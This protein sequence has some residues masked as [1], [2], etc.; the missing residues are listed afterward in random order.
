MDS[1]VRPLW[2]GLW[3][4]KDALLSLPTPGSGP[5]TGS[6]LDLDSGAPL[7]QQSGERNIQGVQSISCWPSCAICVAFF[8]H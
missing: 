1:S 2:G 6:T 5:R 8:V 3:H 7:P 4:L